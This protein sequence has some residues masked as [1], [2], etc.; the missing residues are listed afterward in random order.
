VPSRRVRD[1]AV[2]AGVM[3]ADSG[4][5]WQGRCKFLKHL[6]GASTSLRVQT[7]F[8]AV[9]VGRAGRAITGAYGFDLEP[10]GQ[11]SL[12]SL[13]LAGRPSQYV[14]RSRENGTVSCRASCSPNSGCL[15]AGL[16]NAC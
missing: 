13:F 2:K 1:L 6:E 11:I 15:E 16:F 9:M 8:M 14:G 3:E 12:D 5:C 7:L 10:H 4:S